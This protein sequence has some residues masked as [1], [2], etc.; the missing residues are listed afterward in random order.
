MEIL[1]ALLRWLTGLIFPFTF[2]PFLHTHNRHY[3]SAIRSIGIDFVRH[4]KYS[5]TR[6]W[7]ILLYVI[8]VTTLWVLN[9]KLVQVSYTK[10]KRLGY[11]SCV[12]IGLD[13]RWLFEINKAN[14]FTPSAHRGWSDTINES[15]FCVHIKTKNDF[16]WSFRTQINHAHTYRFERASS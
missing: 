14:F 13:F 11:V 3:L 2:D 4:K 7:F 6:I 10:R 8:A 5:Y 15:Y 1:A 16:R 12:Y 9:G